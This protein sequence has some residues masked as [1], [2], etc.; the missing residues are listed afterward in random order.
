MVIP[1]RSSNPALLVAAF[2]V[3][4]V[5]VLSWL[6]SGTSSSTLLLYTTQSRPVAKSSAIAATS[7]ITLTRALDGVAASGELTNQMSVYMMASVTNSSSIDPSSAG[8]GDPN[9]ECGNL[10]GGCRLEVKQ[11]TAVVDGVDRKVAII[12]LLDSGGK[13]IGT[14]RMMEIPILR[15]LRPAGLA[16][17]FLKVMEPVNV[18]VTRAEVAPEFR[19]SGVGLFLWRQSNALAWWFSGSGHTDLVLME[20]ENPWVY[21]LVDKLPARSMLWDYGFFKLYQLLPAR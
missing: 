21:G 11:A 2:A 10:P 19:G 1:N 8:L 5:L 6:L 20:A 17:T 3:A 14:I 13:V 9:S 7:M 12:R 15:V 4:S 18:W 16:S